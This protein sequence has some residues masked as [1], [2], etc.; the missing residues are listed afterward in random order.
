MS[1]EETQLESPRGLP[2]YLNWL[3]ALKGK[4]ALGVFEYPLF[5]DARITEEMTEGLGPYQ[6][7]NPVALRE[8]PGLVRPAIILRAELHVKFCPPD[9]KKTDYEQYHGGS[10]TDEV[11]ALS[12]L[13][14]GIRL[15]SGGYDSAI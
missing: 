11:A 10:H 7:L 13:A 1:E 12:S 15:K 6:F 14:L 4:P 9:L 2:I 8:G 5:T 3:A